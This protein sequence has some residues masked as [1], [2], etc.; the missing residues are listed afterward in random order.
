[1]SSDAKLCS[2]EV[3]PVPQSTRTNVFIRVKIDERIHK[4][5]IDIAELIK[6]N[7]ALD[8]FDEENEKEKV[9]V[10][11]FVRQHANDFAQAIE[12]VVE[13]GRAAVDGAFEL[14]AADLSRL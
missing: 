12:R 2:V 5:R 7:D 4:A 11:V 1:M 10:K 9:K 3:V 13:E 8:S 6:F 14:N